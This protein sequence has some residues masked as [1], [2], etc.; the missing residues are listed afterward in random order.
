MNESEQLLL[1]PI[2]FEEPFL[3]LIFLLFVLFSPLLLFLLLLLCLL[4]R[5]KI[6]VNQ[7]TLKKKKKC[8]WNNHSQEKKKKKNR[9]KKKKSRFVMRVPTIETN[10]YDKVRSEEPRFRF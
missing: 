3:L 1:K 10:L 5:E 8:Q 4:G 6:K 7:L 2:A 9:K